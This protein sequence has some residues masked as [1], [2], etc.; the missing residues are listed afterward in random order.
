[1]WRSSSPEGDEAAAKASSSGYSWPMHLVSRLRHPMQT[2][3]DGVRNVHRIF[4][5][6]HSQQLRVPLRSLRRLVSD[7]AS[8]RTSTEGR[9][10]GPIVIG[11]Q[12]CCQVDEAM[13]PS[14]TTA[15]PTK[16]KAAQRTRRKPR[17][18]ANVALTH[19]R[20]S[21]GRLLM[22]KDRGYRH[23]TKPR[24]SWESVWGADDTFPL[25]N[26]ASLAAFAGEP[27]HHC[28]PISSILRAHCSCPSHAY[29]TCNR[30]ELTTYGFECSRPEI[31]H[32]T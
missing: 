7:P 8:G 30:L 14:S 12:L 29:N 3:S 2:E 13:S 9:S 5:R 16:A 18:P 27:P 25:L 11:R 6:L 20:R 15:G 22:A 28:R 31:G 19:F 32:L 4:L 24:P 23:T 21:P 17:P 10:L 26:W 1:M